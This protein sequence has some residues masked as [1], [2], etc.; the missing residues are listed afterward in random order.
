MSKLAWREKPDTSAIEDPVEAA[1][2]RKDHRTAMA[3]RWRDPEARKEDKRRKRLPLDWHDWMNCPA[4]EGYQTAGC[5]CDSWARTAQE[6]RQSRR[7][8]KRQEWSSAG[9]YHIRLPHVKTLIDKQGRS[10]TV[11]KQ[12]RWAGRNES[13]TST[14]LTGHLGRRSA[15]HIR[16]PCNRSPFDPST[17]SL[18]RFF[19]P[20]RRGAGRRA[21]RSRACLPC[22]QPSWVRGIWGHLF[23][24]RSGGSSSRGLDGGPR[25][26]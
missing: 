19:A 4:P 18:F 9:G 25:N 16:S 2:I 11:K 13:E 14:P 1:R 5:S 7:A 10:I 15:G 20:A 22:G 6:R 26:I 17:D 24:V 12:I 21:I 23:A 3:V 8:R